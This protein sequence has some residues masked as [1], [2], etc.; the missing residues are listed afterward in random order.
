MG[1]NKMNVW[2]TFA[3]GYIAGA[4]TIAVYVGLLFMGREQRIYEEGVL[5]GKQQQQRAV[6]RT[7]STTTYK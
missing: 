7:E 6:W 1:N 2:I 3:I 5:A 4:I